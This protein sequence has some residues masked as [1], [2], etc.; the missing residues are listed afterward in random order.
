MKEATVLDP[1]AAVL[2][3]EAKEKLEALQLSFEAKREYILLE[4]NRD[5]TD[6]GEELK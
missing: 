2:I 6:I 4:L 1:R 3:F 5:L